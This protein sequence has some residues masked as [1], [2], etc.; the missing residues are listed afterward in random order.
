MTSKDRG[1]GDTSLVNP[2]SSERSKITPQKVTK[3]P[4]KSIM[5]KRD[6]RLREKSSNRKDLDGTGVTRQSQ[7]VHLKDASYEM[8]PMKSP[9][10]S[11]SSTPNGEIGTHGVRVVFEPAD[12]PATTKSESNVFSNSPTERPAIV[13]EDDVDE[14][15]ETSPLNGV[16]T[17]SNGGRILVGE[18][19]MEN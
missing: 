1:E 14:D 18:S 17:T 5:K 13:D 7:S 2:P 11:T 6:E 4:I 10:H 15:A 12:G 3:G 9:R 19:N 8:H 16:F